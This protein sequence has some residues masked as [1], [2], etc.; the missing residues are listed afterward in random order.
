MTQKEQ[1]ILLLDVR[2]VWMHS[3]LVR[4]QAGPLL[5]VQGAAD[6]HRRLCRTPITQITQEPQ[7]EPFYKY[8]TQASLPQGGS[9]KACGFAQTNAYAQIASGSGTAKGGLD[10]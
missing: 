10:A 7:V 1:C 9:S 3:N 5:L 8:T 2:L 6:H 4:L